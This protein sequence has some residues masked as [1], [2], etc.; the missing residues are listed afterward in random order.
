[1]AASKPTS[2]L[3]LATNPFNLHLVSFRDLNPR[4][5]CSL[6]GYRAYPMS[7]STRYLRSR[8][9][10]SLISWRSLSTANLL[11]GRSTSPSIS[12][13]VY[14]RVVSG[15]TR[16]CRP[17]LAFNPYTQV[18]QTICT[19]VLV[20]SSTQ[21]SLGFNLLRRRSTGFGSSTND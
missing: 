13:E 19:S 8:Q 7:P 4:L 16:Y 14:L 2:T 11:I 6:H 12:T 9:V 5:G 20:R 15:G 3:S 18:I 17:R 21:F 1:M 10:R